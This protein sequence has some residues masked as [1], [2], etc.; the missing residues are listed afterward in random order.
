[1]F[2][3]SQ[4]IGSS[5]GSM[6]TSGRKRLPRDGENRLSVPPARS[7][8]MFLE[9][10]PHH[11]DP[12]KYNSNDYRWNQVKPAKKGYF[13]NGQRRDEE[14]IDKSSN[15]MFYEET[16]KGPRLGKGLDGYDLDI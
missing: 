9:E 7:N 11:P 16:E 15:Y 5:A 8:S 12:R 3:N 2:R 6:A 1:M 14:D 4:R 10:P 13:N